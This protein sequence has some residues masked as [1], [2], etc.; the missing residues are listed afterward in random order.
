[1]RALLLALALLAAPVAGCL[2]GEESPT[3][4]SPEWSFEDTEGQTHSQETAAGSPT[5]IFYMATWCPSCQELTSEM[6][7]VH[8][9]YASQGVDV[10]SVT[11]DPG[12][13]H[14]D[15]ERWKAEH[16]QA[17]PHGI[18][19][20]AQ[21]Q[22][23]YGVDSQSNVVVLDGEGLKVEH[24]GYGKATAEEVGAVLDELGA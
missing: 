8:D 1:M 24:W 22:R 4:G 14:E 11:V 17:W 9:E 13:T 2:S 16:E 7:Q 6:K 12:E 20:D 5:V 18:D 21:L 10:F 19:E 15:L 23:T 3:G